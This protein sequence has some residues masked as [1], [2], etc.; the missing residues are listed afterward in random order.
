VV[1]KLL[2]VPVIVAG[3]FLGIRVLLIGMIIHSLVSYFVNSYY[4]GRL[5]DYPSGEQ[6]GDI[7]PSF[8][9]ALP[10]AGLVMLLGFI[11]GV[12]APVML[13]IQMVTLTLLTVILGKTLKMRG[14]IE[15]RSIILEKVPSLARIL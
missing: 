9:V 14:Y 3:I 13:I 6:L 8:L 10:A 4:S 15:I 12:P 11:P 7:V 2:A 5:I 1:K